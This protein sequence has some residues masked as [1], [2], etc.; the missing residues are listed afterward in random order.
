MKTINGQTNLTPE[1][2]D[3]IK[4]IVNTIIDIWVRLTGEKKR[5]K[6]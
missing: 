5:V 2:G 4:T 6:K 1:G 3:I